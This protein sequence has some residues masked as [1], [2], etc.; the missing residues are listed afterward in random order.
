MTWHDIQ[1]FSFKLFACLINK[2]IL[3]N[4]TTMG[5]I[6]SLNID[7]YSNACTH[8]LFK[9]L[10]FRTVNQLPRCTHVLFEELICRT[11]NFQEKILLSENKQI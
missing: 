8:V 4:I 1:S 2:L 7:N 6:L 11:T 9:G 5:L 10:I 3:F